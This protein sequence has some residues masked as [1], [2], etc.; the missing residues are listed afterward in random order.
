MV[1]LASLGEGKLLA[2]KIR[3]LVTLLISK[4]MLPYLLMVMLHNYMP[5]FNWDSILTSKV[6]KGIVLNQTNSHMSAENT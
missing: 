6:Y 5:H 3:T 2:W 1:L 4:E